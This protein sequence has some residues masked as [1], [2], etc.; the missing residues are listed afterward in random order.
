MSKELFE[1][2]LREYTDEER[3]DAMIDVITGYFDELE[4]NIKDI[5]TRLKTMEEIHAEDISNLRIRMGSYERNSSSCPE[6][7]L[8][9]KISMLQAFQTEQTSIND[10]ITKHMNDMIKSVKINTE[11]LSNLRSCTVVCFLLVAVFMLLVSFA[12]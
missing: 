12:R 9:K 8:K 7:E 2:R 5:E 11:K 6:D 4:K 3:Q 10:N 1:I